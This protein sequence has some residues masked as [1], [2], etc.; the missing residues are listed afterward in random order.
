VNKINQLAEAGLFDPLHNLE[1]RKH[2]VFHGT[3]DIIVSQG[4]VMIGNA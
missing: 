2:F 1:S 4:K 3:N